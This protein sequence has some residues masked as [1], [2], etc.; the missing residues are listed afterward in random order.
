MSVSIRSQVQFYIYAHRH[1]VCK[2]LGSRPRFTKHTPRQEGFCK[3]EWCKENSNNSNQSSNN[4]HNT[5]NSIHRN[6]SNYNTSNSN[7]S[8]NSNKNI[9]SN[10]STNSSN[11]NSL[12]HLGQHWLT[13]HSRALQT[14]EVRDTTCKS[15]ASGLQHLSTPA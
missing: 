13:R 5:R 9:T 12:G 6:S 8:T 2:G 11:G 4:S 14:Q 7:N 3:A 15:E 1:V 10:N